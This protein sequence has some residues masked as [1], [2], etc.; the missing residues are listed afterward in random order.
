MTFLTIEQILEKY[1]FVFKSKKNAV[2]SIARNRNN[3]RSVALKIRNQTFFEEEKL[4]EWI[5]S[6]TYEK[7]IRNQF[8]QTNKDETQN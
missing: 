3:I 1:P 4:L 8:N 2:L 5:R 6:Q 7:K